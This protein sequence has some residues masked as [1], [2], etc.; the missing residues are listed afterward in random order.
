M[1]TCSNDRRYEISFSL[2]MA[3]LPSLF[4]IISTQPIVR[5]LDCFEDG[6]KLTWPIITSAIVLA[7]SPWYCV[8]A[9]AIFTTK[10]GHP[11]VF[12][13]CHLICKQQIRRLQKSPVEFTHSSQYK[14]GEMRYKKCLP[15]AKSYTWELWNT[16]SSHCKRYHVMNIK[17]PISSSCKWVAR[18]KSKFKADLLISI[19]NISI[20]RLKG[21]K[22]G[23]NDLESEHK[24]LFIK[25]DYCNVNNLC[26]LHSNH[27]Y[28]P[29]RKEGGGQG[30]RGSSVS[31][32]DGNPWRTTFEK[33][34][35]R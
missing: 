25:Q 30:G 2:L 4:L 33:Q 27:L 22:T 20:A 34:W 13:P 24:M 19:A 18:R 9:R 7:S 12:V 32:R 23:P 29:S 35:T 3:F 21:Y 10:I 17:M 14:L 6:Q 28:T 15:W 26:C 31:Q 11:S 5:N 8:Q 1:S 16:P